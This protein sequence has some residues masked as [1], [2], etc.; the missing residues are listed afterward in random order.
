M[1]KYFKFREKETVKQAIQ[2]LKEKNK[3]IKN[4]VKIDKNKKIKKE[5]NSI[6]NNINENSNNDKDDKFNLLLGI[7]SKLTELSFFDVYSDTIT[8][9]AKDYGIENVF[10]WKYKIIEND[11]DK[12]DKKETIYGDYDTCTMREWVKQ[13]FFESPEPNTEFQFL[14]IDTLNKKNINA[15]KWFNCENILYTKILKN[16]K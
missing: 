14:F 2:R 13:K 3:K 15:N 8:K 9:I 7:V 11:N 1:C 4:K 16:E 5:K 12:K 10:L 6:I